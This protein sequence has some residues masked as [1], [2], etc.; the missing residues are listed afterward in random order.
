MITIENRWVLPAAPNARNW[1]CRSGKFG[2]RDGRP[3]ESAGGRGM[4]TLS[5]WCFGRCR[6]RRRY[7]LVLNHPPDS[8]AAAHRM[9]PEAQERRE[10]DASC[11]FGWVLQYLTTP[12]GLSPRFP[13]APLGNLNATD[14]SVGDREAQ[15]SS[16]FPSP[17]HRRGVRNP[18]RGTDNRARLASRLR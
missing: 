8:S 1:P 18:R 13:S 2:Y 15:R 11:G 12:P 4:T 9:R 7:P 5:R 14:H 16:G 10:I 3:G 17:S 6:R